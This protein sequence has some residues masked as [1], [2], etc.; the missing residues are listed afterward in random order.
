MSLN[1][2]VER[3]VSC[4]LTGTA[5]WDSCFLNAGENCR[6]TGE[7]F[8]GVTWSGGFTSKS[9]SISGTNHLGGSLA[10]YDSDSI[11]NAGR[12]WS[13]SDSLQTSKYNIYAKNIDLKMNISKNTMTGSGNT[14]E[15]VLKYIHTYSKVHGS[16]SITPGAEG[17]A[18]SFS[19]SNT[20]KQWSL[21]CTVTNT[22]YFFSM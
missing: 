22:P 11:P 14:A 9:H 18:G 8:I 4:D 10:I 1:K 12:A 17:V 19:L 15:A 6:A 5:H 20:D 16:I 21:V 2:I 3:G 7:D 13:F